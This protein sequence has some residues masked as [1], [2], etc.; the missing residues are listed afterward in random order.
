MEKL[1][2]EHDRMVEEYDAMNVRYSEAQYELQVMQE[3]LKSV[4][5]NISNENKIEREETEMLRKEVQT[6][7]EANEKLIQK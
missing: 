4:P 2:T 6:L 3:K 5:V 7:K 1:R